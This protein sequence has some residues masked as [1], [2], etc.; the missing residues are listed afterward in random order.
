MRLICPQCKLL[1]LGVEF[2][3]K[4]TYLQFTSA[5]CFL[6]M[7]FVFASQHWS[8]TNSCKMDFFTFSTLGWDITGFI[9]AYF[10][11]AL[12]TSGLVILRWFG[13]FSKRGH[14]FIFKDENFVDCWW[15]GGNSTPSQTEE[16]GIFILRT[17][18]G[19]GSSQRNNC[20]TQ[21]SQCQ[22]GLP[23]FYNWVEL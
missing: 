8:D 15:L 23:T 21:K 14:S 6:E 9:L 3:K 19:F 11:H 2:H 17:F 10:I 13:N 18:F 7:L 1:A 4:H 22:W 12:R 5:W 20:R 16:H